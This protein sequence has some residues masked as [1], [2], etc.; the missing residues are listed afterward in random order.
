MSD[1]KPQPIL[2]QVSREWFDAAREGKLL[3]Q[4]CAACERFQFYPRAHCIHCF[5]GRPEWHEASG[6]G[7]LHTFSVVYQTPN[8]EFADDCPYVL[9]IV[10]LE[11]DVRMTSRLV[12]VAEEDIACDMPVTVTFGGWDELSLPF[13]TADGSA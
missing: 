1:T 9:A 12:D 2:D 4:R 5:A 11:E 10:D 3:I 13:F 6:R 8:P 7:R